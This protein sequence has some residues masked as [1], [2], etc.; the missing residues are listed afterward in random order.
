MNT[1]RQILAALSLA[2]LSAA[3]PSLAQQPDKIRRI[4]FL[5]ARSRSTASNPEVYDAFVAGMRDLGYVEGR[6]L[7]IEWRFADGKFERLPG[8]A[9]ELVRMNLEAIVT[10]ATPPAEALRQ[11]TR[12]IPIVFTTVNDPVSSG[13]AASL[14][15][16][17]GNLTGLSLMT[18][19][20]S[21]KH[22][23]LLK[24]MMPKLSRIGVFIN[25]G[26]SSH[27]VYLKSVQAAAQQVGIRI[28]P[29]EAG[30]PEEIE[31]GFAAMT[32][33]RAE[34]VIFAADSFYIH[35]RRQTA[36]L[37]L[38]SKIPSM[39]YTREQVEAGGLM[40]YG[41][42][43]SDFN[44]R[45]AT[46]VDKILKG[47]KPA[48]LPIEQPTTIHLAINRKT[49]KALGLIIPQEILLRADEVIE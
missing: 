4:G 7:I 38:K 42:N 9:A 1:R 43:L 30:T 8:L 14:A 24:I 49:A 47:A 12:S 21:P 44:R 29:V 10:H 36:A 22:V 23:E 25:P 18:V 17:A 37:A 39:F 33:E 27:R 19:D 34:A 35:Q 2:T 28:L 5:S 40:S 20:I 6:N 46:Y 48:D 41:Q 11:A 16:P 3:L 32:R 13:F 26:N 45:A 31:R 15:R